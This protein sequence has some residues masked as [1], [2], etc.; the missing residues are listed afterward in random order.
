MI[1]KNNLFHPTGFTYALTLTLPHPE[2]GS[3]SFPLE[4]P[5]NSVFLD[6]QVPVELVLHDSW[7]KVITM[8]CT[9]AL[10][11]WDAQG[12]SSHAVRK[13]KLTHTNNP[14]V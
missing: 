5:Y 6:Q 14:Y 8:S 12:A 2:M 9:C 1:K 4:A 10:F 7:D 11:P 3:M 13:L